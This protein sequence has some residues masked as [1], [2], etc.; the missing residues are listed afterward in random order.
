MPDVVETTWY[1]RYR[2]DRVMLPLVAETVV[3]PVHDPSGVAVL[4][5]RT[6]IVTVVPEGAVTSRVRVSQPTVAPASMT[7]DT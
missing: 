4:P 6:W 5:D 7:P 2:A 3:Q 1:C